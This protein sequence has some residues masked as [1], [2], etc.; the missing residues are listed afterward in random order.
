MGNA[1]T[2]PIIDTYMV[3]N[4]VG[5]IDNLSGELRGFH[6]LPKI[7]PNI[8]TSLKN[9]VL[10][11]KIN[12]IMKESINNDNIVRQHT[13]DLKILFSNSFTIITSKKTR[14]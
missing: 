10:S 11:L 6:F 3:P 9:T 14:G 5:Y 1:I 12:N 8:E 13:I 2:I 4:I 7:N